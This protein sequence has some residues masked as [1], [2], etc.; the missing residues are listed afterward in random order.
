MAMTNCRTGTKG[1]VSIPLVERFWEKVN[2]AGECW[3]WLGSKTKNGYG[4]IWNNGKVEYAHRVSFEIHKGDIPSGLEIDH[5]CENPSCV[6][7][8]H[9]E[10]VTHSENIKRA[11]HRIN[12]ANKRKTHCKHGH[13]LEGDNL[14]SGQR[15]KRQC[16]ECARRRDRERRVKAALAKARGESVD[17]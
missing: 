13:A 6:N 2:K 3:V 9:L 10:T 4:Q 15:G 1:F 5:L 7:P 14:R 16:R 12:Y 17:K 8:D 11:V